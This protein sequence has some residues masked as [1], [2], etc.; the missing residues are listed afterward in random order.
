[1]IAALPAHGVELVDDPAQADVIACHIE[2][3]PQLLVR[4]PEKAFV[5]HVHGLYW[6]EYEW[7]RWALDANRRVM[8]AIR[9]ADAVT[10]PSEWVAQAIR[11]HSSRQVTV[12]NHGVDADAWRSDGHDGYV[13]WNKTR[14]DPVCDP[15]PPTQLARAMPDVPFVLAFTDGQAP[16]NVTEVGRES[17]AA[18]AERVRRAGAYLC[19]TRE[20]FGVGTL[21]AMAAG[22]PIVGWR[23][24]GQ[25]E[26]IEHGVD[27]WLCE[28]GDVEGLAAGVR[29][30]LENRQSAG[31][32][33]RKKAERFTWNNAAAIYADVYRRALEARRQDRP[34][35]SVI[36][37]AYK[38]ER[39]L[40]ECLRSVEGQTLRDI[41]CV[42][43]DDASPDGCGEIARGFAERDPR[44]RVVT[45]ET[46][47]YLAGARNVGVEH[48][49]GQ[50][51]LPLDADDRLTPIA[52]EILSAALDR[53]RSIHVA[54]GN[55]EFIKDD[56]ELE[57][58]GTRYGLGHSGWPME[59][60]FDWQIEKARNLLPY[61]SMFR[62]EAWEA[63]GG[64]RE[65]FRTAEDADLW[66]RLSSYGFRPRMVTSAD[67]LTYRNREESMSRVEGGREWSAW[68]P[69]A[70]DPTL[71]PA[72][73]ATDNQLPVPSA[74]PPAVSVVIPVGP[75]HGR[76]V[77]DAV[78]SVDAQTFRQW[79]CIVVNDSGEDLP[80]LPSWVRVIDTRDTAVI[81]SPDGSD[82]WIPSGVAAARNAGIAAARGRYYLPL[83]A[84]DYFQPQ[85]LQI[86][87]EAALKTG[88]VIYSDFWDDGGWDVAEDGTRTP[89]PP[90]KFRP[91]ATADWD[92][93]LLTTRGAIAA[94]TQLTP[95]ALWREV[96]GYDEAIP[97]WEDWAF[98]L[99][100]A[101]RG[102][103][104]RRVPLPLWTYRKHTGSRREDNY[105]T[106]R[107]V[108]EAA[109]M[110]RFGRY[111]QG[112]KLMACKTCGGGRSYPVTAPTPSR[113][114]QPQEATLMRS[115]AA[116][117]GMVTYNAPSGTRYRVAGGQ[118]QW[119]LPADVD[120][121]RQRGFLV[122]AEPQAPT[123]VKTTEPELTAPRND[124]PAA[125]SP[126]EQP[127]AGAAEAQPGDG[128]VTLAVKPGQSL[129]DVAAAAG[130][131]DPKVARK[132]TPRARA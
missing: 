21:E 54:Y 65:R 61:A 102:H 12:V 23:W 109:I 127:T 15:A 17:F 132:R 31:E 119:V 91:Y 66:C 75:G 129:E 60:R 76:Y 88:D 57:D 78:D 74:D 18:A 92:A 26:F 126:D 124:A 99:S 98:Q 97:S 89:H 128:A 106:R 71:T 41:E 55:V 30:A 131:P 117:A 49:R 24:G 9:V 34:K 40:D 38:L 111:W 62:R 50:Y 32:A 11:R 13:L 58:Y 1:M 121:M 33:A 105:E 45:N 118:E 96:G 5:S 10:A 103:C 27:G 28:P 86:M 2:I 69:W 7:P 90:G 68:F 64:Y 35:V 116:G 101:A 52:C 87:F 107:T 44:F 84:D 22:V 70:R 115:S 43:V 120:F 125:V 95:V 16:P 122:V 77:L 14:P 39:Y 20:T 6:G 37:T 4:Y 63:V 46:N 112:E 47:R 110:E 113:G 94:V 123:A 48:A 29:W 53:D 56:G 81:P 67:V 25:A 130:A 108:G 36:V 83:D 19:T 59:F 79:E 8:E 114:Q 3:P 51:I 42:V 104:S 73:A 80:R 100:L 72:G 85:A 82:R 93:T